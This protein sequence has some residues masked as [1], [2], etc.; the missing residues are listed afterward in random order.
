M[1]KNV[2][3]CISK[4]RKRTQRDLKK[5]SFINK[6]SQSKPPRFQATGSNF[7]KKKN[8]SV[9]EP[10]SQENIPMSHQIEETYT[11]Q[12]VQPV[13][14]N[15]S[16]TQIF[17]KQIVYPQNQLS[18]VRY[19]HPMHVENCYPPVQQKMYHQFQ[20]PQFQ[21]LPASQFQNVYTPPMYSMLN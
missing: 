19:Y 11:T 18:T 8:S 6:K 14:Q 12:P 10:Y 4:H 2:T 20:L 21:N 5:K 15:A 17:P 13:F 7:N 3:F 16:Q 1:V 9:R